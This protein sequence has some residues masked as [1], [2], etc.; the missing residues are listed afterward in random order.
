MQKKSTA[1]LFKVVMNGRTAS[2]YCKGKKVHRFKASK[3]VI[4]NEIS[5]AQAFEYKGVL[6]DIEIGYRFRVDLKLKKIVGDLSAG[7]YRD[8]IYK[9]DYILTDYSNNF[10]KTIKGKTIK[11]RPYLSRNEE[12]YI[13]GFHLLFKAPEEKQ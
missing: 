6:Y 4:S 7:I 13:E 5:H 12:V 2:I 10:V 8:S 11:D 1:K 3:S 9:S